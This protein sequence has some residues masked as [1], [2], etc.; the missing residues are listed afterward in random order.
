MISCQKIADGLEEKE[1]PS[2]GMVV[3]ISLLGDV[4]IIKQIASNTAF[5]KVETDVDGRRIVQIIFGE[6]VS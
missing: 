2:K 3:K 1:T 4:Y 5:R 6:K